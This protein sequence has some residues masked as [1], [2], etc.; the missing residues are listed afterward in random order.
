MIGAIVGDAARIVTKDLR[1]ERATG[2][3][4]T[5]I[6]PFGIV[7]LL[8]FGFG[9]DP[10]LQVRG[11]ERSVLAEVAPGLFWITVLLAL[12]LV[13]GRAFAIESDDGSLDAL[14]VA[15][16]HPGA[17]LGGKAFV[18]AAE[19]VLLELLVGAGA[20]LMFDVT[21]EDPLH[22]VLVMA[23]TTV[24][25]AGAGTLFLA[26]VAGQRG[27][28]TLGPL[29]VLPAMAPVLIGATAATGDA[30]YG[31]GS[32]GAAWT[33]ALV[34]F[35]LLYSMAGIVGAGALLEDV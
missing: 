20:M 29:L 23:S 12:L 33:W 26:V 24:A 13:V 16:V 22:L 28:D 5:Q 6:L 14:L 18:V 3:I 17:I 11:G 35:A 9:V 34:A 19:L 8:L 32:G 25:L 31:A 4:T 10:A 15:G 21:I 30:L 27:R 2:V 7:M 1:I